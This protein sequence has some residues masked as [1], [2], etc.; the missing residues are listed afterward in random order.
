MVISSLLTERRV[1]LNRA[2]KA[3]RGSMVI[4]SSGLMYDVDGNVAL[5]V[6]DLSVNDGRHV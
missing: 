1:L 5:N 4:H 6:N 3:N 2:D